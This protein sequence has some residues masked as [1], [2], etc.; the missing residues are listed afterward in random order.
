MCN[1]EV[2]CAFLGWG[3]PGDPSHRAVWFVGFEGSG[4]WTEDSLGHLNGR[5]FT[6]WDDGRGGGFGQPG[7]QVEAWIS[8]ICCGVSRGYECKWQDRWQQYRAEI[9]RQPNSRIFLTNAFPLWR[10]N[11]NE[12]PPTYQELFG[13]AAYG[14]E[15][16]QATRDR[17]YPQIRMRR[18]WCRPQAILCFGTT[19]WPEF[20][21]LLELNGS[22]RPV[23]R[24]QV[25][26]YDGDDQHILLIPF[27]AYGGMNHDELMQPIIETL[28]GW[29][30]ALP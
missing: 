5:Y 2:A 29:G 26:A 28:G 12:W 23:V 4:V 11:Q 3:D 24:D 20:T 7:D 6:S 14:H 9:V 22:G 13:Y 1:F 21:L 8:K 30:V 10:P 16:I 15:Y 18:V 19:R 27:L 25:Y 17:R